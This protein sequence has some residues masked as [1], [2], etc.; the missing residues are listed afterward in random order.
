MISAGQIRE[1]LQQE[2]PGWELFLV[3]VTVRPG[4]RIT[5]YVDS[6]KG[7]TIDECKA[8]SRHIE[9]IF[10]REVEDYELEVSSPGL[11]NP[12]KL[13]V[14]FIKNIGRQ[15]DVLRTDGVKST[16]RLVLANDEIVRLEIGIMERDS[17]T[18]KK[19]MVPKE[20]DIKHN[21]IK[22]AK[23]VVSLKK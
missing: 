22:S 9:S 16:G 15:I 14:Q 23:V 1:C 5:V 8:V 18:G 3:D 4:N 2:L 19:I 20:L 7:V 13:P 21:E 17:K 12:L 11:D 10:S 6:F